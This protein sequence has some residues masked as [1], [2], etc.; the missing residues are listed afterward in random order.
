MNRLERRRLA[1][2]AKLIDAGRR[3][4]AD[5]GVE[6]TTI[7][8]ITDAADVGRGSFYNFFDTKDQLVEAI[9]RDVL[10]SLVQVEYFVNDQ[11]SDPRLAL[12]AT[13]RYAFD[14][15]D[16]PAV[17][18]FIV[19]TTSIGGP[20]FNQFHDV[21]S[22]L[23]ERGR[24]AGRFSF[25]DIEVAVVLTATMMLGGI[26]GVLVGRLSRSHTDTVVE[27]V[28]RMLGVPGAVARKIVSTPLPS[29]GEPLP[30]NPN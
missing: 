4:V 10:D 7:Q 3:I 6:A 15:L 16:N 22:A 21:T 19:R 23:L 2:R 27:H 17:A 20:F 29:P 24:D 26:E 14:M 12:A 30:Q 28:L 9:V 8:D 1:T 18:W 25:D 13:L 11:F 5:K